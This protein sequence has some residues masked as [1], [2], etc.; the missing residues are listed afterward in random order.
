MICLSEE[1]TEENILLAGQI[2]NKE[3]RFKTI[4]QMD[5]ESGFAYHFLML[6]DEIKDKSPKEKML[7]IIKLN[8]Q[9]NF[10]ANCSE[11]SHLAAIMGDTRKRFSAKNLADKLREAKLNDRE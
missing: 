5:K 4:A 10:I 3:P 2:S 8:G 1:Y 7:E 9:I 11:L 6:F